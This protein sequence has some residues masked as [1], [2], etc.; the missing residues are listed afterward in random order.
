MNHEEMI[1]L[2]NEAYTYCEKLYSGMSKFIKNIE[3]RN[4]TELETYFKNI[5]EGFNWVLEV[6]VLSIDIHGETIDLE[7]IQQKVNIFVEGYNNLD[8]LFVR[9]VV[10]YELMP[11][12]E[13][14]YN[15]FYKALNIL[16][17]VK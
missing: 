10:E 14:I 5:L 3:D 9:D 12:V 15:V 13:I 2:I 4:L 16:Q 11:Q 17:D 6:E 1:E 8:F 7:S